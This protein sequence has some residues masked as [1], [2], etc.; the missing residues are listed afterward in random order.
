M[1][2]FMHFIELGFIEV[3]LFT[4]SPDDRFVEGKQDFCKSH[5]LRKLA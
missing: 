4:W 1:Q 3:D 5:G 2:R